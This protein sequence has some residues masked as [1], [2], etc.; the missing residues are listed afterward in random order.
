M[1]DQTRRCNQGSGT[2]LH[3]ID[4]CFNLFLLD[5][6]NC[7][8]CKGSMPLITIGT[9]MTFIA[10]QYT[11]NVCTALF[12]KYVREHSYLCITIYS[13]NIR[14]LFRFVHPTPV[15]GGDN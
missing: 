8:R 1:A 2:W 7:K 13:Q 15:N 14:L 10:C 12:S 6:T 3:T 5:F 11:F 9:N 4:G